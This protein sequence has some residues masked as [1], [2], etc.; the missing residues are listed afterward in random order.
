MSK[1]STP[2]QLRGQR[3]EK[4]SRSD[5]D[6][7]RIFVAID[8]Q[9]LWYSS[10]EQF[11]LTA[12]VDFE[13]LRDMILRKTLARIPRSPKMVAYTVT[14]STK[15]K[16]SGEIKYVGKKNDRFL[17]ALEHLG[18]EV[19]NRNMHAEKGIKKPF[20]TDW[21][22]GIALDAIKHIDNYDT[23]TLVS[24]DGDY[25]MLIE[26]LKERGK[27]VEVF[28]FQSTASRLLHVAANRVIHITKDQLYFQ[29]PRRGNDKTKTDAR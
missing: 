16:A 12:R 17:S 6:V 2:L 18:F 26:D 23:F 27:F 29:E 5:A 8:V 14:A 7:E 20:H 25:A 13:K 10:R 21:D 1:S 15:I 4:V 19:R 11:G 24:G 28:T 22:I 3:T 9:N